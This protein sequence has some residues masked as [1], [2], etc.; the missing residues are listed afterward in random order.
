MYK[1]ELDI[2]EAERLVNMIRREAKLTA[3]ESRFLTVKLNS[4]VYD[5]NSMPTALME[6]LRQACKKLNIT[7]KGER[8]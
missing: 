2:L 4:P 5:F 1:R 8:L 3:E 6:K 7:Y